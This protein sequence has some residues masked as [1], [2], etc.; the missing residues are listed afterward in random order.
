MA[1]CMGSVYAILK[2]GMNQLPRNLACESDGI[3]AKGVAPWYTVARVE[4][5]WRRFLSSA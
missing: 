4:Y 2:A 1:V 3:R 5:V